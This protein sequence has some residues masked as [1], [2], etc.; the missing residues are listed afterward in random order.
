M[1]KQTTEVGRTACGHALAAGESTCP[2]CPS[3]DVSALAAVG[4]L[5]CMTCNS[6]VRPDQKP[7][8][9]CHTPD[10]AVAYVPPKVE[11][12]RPPTSRVRLGVGIGVVVLVALA[13]TGGGAALHKK[14]ERDRIRM[15]Y[16]ASAT[17]DLVAAVER[18]AEAIGV[19]IDVLVRVRRV[20]IARPRLQPKRNAL[21]AARAQALAAGLDGDAAVVDAARAA[22]R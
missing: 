3:V 20:C 13:A 22:G 6:P 9:H 16:G 17:D 14:D 10:P 12:P 19:P 21:A 11:L 4:T 7:C 5:V 2:V 15:A 18:D 1:P 8:P